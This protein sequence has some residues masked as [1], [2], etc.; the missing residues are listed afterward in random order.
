MR[1]WSSTS[2]LLFEIE[3]NRFLYGMLRAIVATMMDVGREKMAVED[4]KTILEME[5]RSFASMS[6]PE[7][8]PFWRK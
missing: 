8:G 1:N 2:L 3:A 7:C 4:F 6:A 5:K